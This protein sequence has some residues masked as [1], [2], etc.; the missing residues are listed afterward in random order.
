MRTVRHFVK[1]A[2]DAEKALGSSGCNRLF[3]DVAARHFN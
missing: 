1:H 2:S 3:L